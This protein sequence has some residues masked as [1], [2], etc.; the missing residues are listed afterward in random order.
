MRYV[1]NI[2]EIVAAEQAERM[3]PKDGEISLDGQTVHVL[4]SN[5]D[6]GNIENVFDGKTDTLMRT[7]GA[8]PMLIELDFPSPRRIEGYG[9]IFGST[10][11]EVIATLYP[12]VQDAVPVVFTQL[13]S[14]T[15]ESPGGTVNFDFPVDVSKVRFEIRDTSQGEPG[16]VHV[17]EL[18]LK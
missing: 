11:V 12:S 15:V 16:H 1:E 4:Y 3:K 10:T 5:P 18:T 8:N 9:L 6:M 17:W 2:T 7:G 13:L 14:G